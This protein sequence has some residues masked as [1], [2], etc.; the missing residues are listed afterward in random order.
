MVCHA[1]TLLAN[2]WATNSFG[3]SEGMVLAAGLGGE[4]IWILNPD[5][6]A[7]PGMKVK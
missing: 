5:D 6:G 7:Q 1:Q 4:E 3:M 2:S